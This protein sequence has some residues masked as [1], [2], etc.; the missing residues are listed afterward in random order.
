VPYVIELL[1]RDHDREAF[2]SGVP[3]LDEY[4]SR[5]ARQNAERGLGRTYVAVRSGE[6]RVVGYYTLSAGAVTFAEVPDHLRRRFPRSPVPVVHLG[7]LATCR[8][9]RGE[10]LGEALLLDALG[11]SLRV[12]H[13]LGIVVVEVRAKTERAKTFYGKYGFEPLIDD[14]LHLYLPLG[15][16]RQALEP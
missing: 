11:R 15:T 7:R 9:V 10:H 13:D 6:A 8:S 3:A 4:L 2:D 12:A 14:P 1:R 16:A 5:Y